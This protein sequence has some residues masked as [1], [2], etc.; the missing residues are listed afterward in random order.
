MLMPFLP[1][2]VRADLGRLL[3][4]LALPPELTRA[5]VVLRGELT[6]D[7]RYLEGFLPEG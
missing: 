2:L 4:E 1:G 3:T 7:Y 5:L 6:P